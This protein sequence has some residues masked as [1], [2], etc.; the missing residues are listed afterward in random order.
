MTL[1]NDTTIPE[2][3]AAYETEI[4]KSKKRVPTKKC[5]VL[6]GVVKD[7][8]GAPFFVCQMEV[9]RTKGTPRSKSL[10]E[11]ELSVRYFAVDCTS[12]S[13]TLC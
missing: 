5:V 11:I 2:Y 4:I 9:Q 12:L 8:D 6:C 7:H 3:I 13:T 10:L 1:K